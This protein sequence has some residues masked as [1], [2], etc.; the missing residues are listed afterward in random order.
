MALCFKPRADLLDGRARNNGQEP[1]RIIAYAFEPLHH[2]AEPLR[3]DRQD[4]HVRILH[5]RSVVCGDFDSIFLVQ[6]HSAFL[7]RT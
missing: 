2:F 6:F 5:G 1:T 3:F 7:T 4:H